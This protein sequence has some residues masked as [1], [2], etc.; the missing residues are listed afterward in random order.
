MNLQCFKQIS[1]SPHFYPSESVFNHEHTLTKQRWC[2]GKWKKKKKIFSFCSSKNFFRHQ[3]TAS[4]LLSVSPS[5]SST[6][7]SLSSSHLHHPQQIICVHSSWSSSST[8]DKYVQ[9]KKESKKKKKKWNNSKK[10]LCKWKQTIIR[11]W[12]HQQLK[13][14]IFNF[15]FYLQIFFCWKGG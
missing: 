12:P 9:Q 13:I 7:S 3:Q 11:C 14:Q 10:F 8:I 15:N 4:P 6:T 2:L 5:L 1:W